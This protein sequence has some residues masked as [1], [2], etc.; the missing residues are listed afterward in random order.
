MKQAGHWH[1]LWLQFIHK[2]MIGGQSCRFRVTL[3]VL[4]EKHSI[5]SN[6]L[7]VK[8]SNK[9]KQGR[10]VLLEEALHEKR[11]KKKTEL[12]SSW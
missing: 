11:K 4:Q 1:I 10:G 12:I 7:E 5:G 3:V 8:V 6:R 9:H 2:Y